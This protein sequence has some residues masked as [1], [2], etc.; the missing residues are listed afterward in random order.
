MSTETNAALPAKK[1]QLTIVGSGIA[2][3]SHLTLQA[4]SAIENA[5]IVCYVVADGATE[6]FI[7]KKNPNSLD[8]Y[9]LYGEDKQRTDT[10]IQMA[11]VS[12]SGHLRSCCYL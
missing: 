7:R 4:V 1:G 5:D 10:Y 9:H 2:S 12:V 11:E 6:A 3:I 8:L